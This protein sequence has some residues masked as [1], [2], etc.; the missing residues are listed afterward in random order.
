MDAFPD[1][2]A[3][4]YLLRD[5]DQVYG[6]QFRRRVPGMRIEEVL[7]GPHSPWQSPFALPGSGRGSQ[8]A[9][10]PTCP[11]RVSRVLSPS[12]H[13]ALP[14]QGCAQRGPVEPLE[15][16]RI[17]SIP[18]V[19]GLHH[20]Y[21]RRAVYSITGQSS[22]HRPFVSTFWSV[23]APSRGSRLTAKPVSRSPRT[24]RAGRTSPRCRE[25]GQRHPASR[26]EYWRRTTPGSGA[27][28]TAGRCPE[29]R[30]REA[31]AIRS[32]LG[33]A[34]PRKSRSVRCSRGPGHGSLVELKLLA[35]GQLL[36]G[37]VAMASDKDGKEPKQAEDERDHRAQIV[38]RS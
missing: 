28:A 27:A 29:L 12:P 3:P 23:S 25:D 7:T 13:T 21:V 35:Q 33:Q 10:P 5:R 1:D 34:G 2:S 6:E 38:A 14:R 37:E 22:L 31:A 32:R 4:P 20:R 26:T 17:I 36:E 9:L 8:R 11:H 30:S 18:E 24:H 19:G 16:G 15:L